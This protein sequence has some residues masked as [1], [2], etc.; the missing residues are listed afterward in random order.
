[1]TANHDSMNLKVVTDQNLAYVLNNE[2][3]RAT[4]LMDS[5]VILPA[6]AGNKAG[7]PPAVDAAPSAVAAH[8]RELT[9][10]VATHGASRG[11]TLSQAATAMRHFDDFMRQHVVH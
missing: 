6:I 1:M 5:L 7:A 4:L 2:E 3:E 10:K 8:L 11:G 9:L